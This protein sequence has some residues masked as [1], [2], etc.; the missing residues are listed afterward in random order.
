M[1]LTPAGAGFDGVEQPKSCGAESRRSGR[2]CFGVVL[3][4]RMPRRGP[5][6]FKSKRQKVTLNIDTKAYRK[7]RELVDQA[8]GVSVSDLV[9]ELLLAV[10]DQVA[11][12]VLELAKAKNHTER[13]LILECQYAEQVGQMAI[14]F[15]RT[16]AQ[17]LAQG[18]EE[19]E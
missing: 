1:S 17:V 18:E 4:L 12:M 16:Y 11:P 10:V 13:M 7:V 3:L 2:Y 19:P 8:P 6:P 5:V 9:S 15:T 14:Q